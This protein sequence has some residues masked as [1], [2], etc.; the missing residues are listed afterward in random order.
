MTTHI[1]SMTGTDV[2][3]VAAMEASQHSQPWSERS[4]YD[5]LDARWHCRVLK[6]NS[7]L[8]GY[9]VTMTAG[10]DEEL[11]TIAVCPEVTGQGYGKT[12]MQAVVRDARQRGADRLLLEVRASNTIAIRLYEQMGF[13][14]DGMRKNYYPVPA[15]PARQTPALREHALLMSLVLG[16]ASL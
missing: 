2:P 10:D 4:F 15:E 14:I 7:L 6:K 8:I 1:E 13:K 5:A 16:S 9:C 11:L 3:D 12:L